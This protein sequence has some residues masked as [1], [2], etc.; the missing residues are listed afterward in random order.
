MNPSHVLEKNFSEL[1]DLF[2]F[3]SFVKPLETVSMAEKITAMEI[4]KKTIDVQE[5]FNDLELR[6]RN[7][8][9][10]LL[11]AVFGAAA[12]IL[13][14]GKFSAIGLKIAGGL[15]L[16][17]LMVWGA[18]WFMDRHWYH[19]LLYGAVDHGRFIEH[20]YWRAIPELRLTETIGRFSPLQIRKWTIHTPRKLD[21]FYG[22]IA[23]V[24]LAFGIFFLLVPPSVFSGIIST[25]ATATNSTVSP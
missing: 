5:H 21:L 14:Q 8:A 4:W 6:I 10:T 17:G 16:G 11:V 12:L 7:Y 19:K 2:E 18:F 25:N 15:L 3:H 22:V 1:L 23:I 13:S 20:R 24:L 9:Q